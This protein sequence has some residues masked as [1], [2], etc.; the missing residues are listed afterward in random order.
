MR[1]YVKAVARSDCIVNTC[2]TVKNR[3]INGRRSLRYLNV[4][5]DFTKKYLAI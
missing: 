5:D 3:D 2:R 4:V 1:G